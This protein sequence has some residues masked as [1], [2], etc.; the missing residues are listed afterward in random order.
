M[1]T[2]RGCRL[3]FLSVLLWSILLLTSIYHLC[4]DKDA[5]LINRDVLLVLANSVLV[6]MLIFGTDSVFNTDSGD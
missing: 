1:S 2:K 3:V 4:N 6:L 5:E